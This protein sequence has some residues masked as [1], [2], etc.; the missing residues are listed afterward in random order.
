MKELQENILHANVT[1]FSDWREQ[2]DFDYERVDSEIIDYVNSSLNYDVL[3]KLID[4]NA[5]DEIAW[6]KLFHQFGIPKD[7]DKSRTVRR[8][9]ESYIN[10]QT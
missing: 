8:H 6:D 1:E 9:I 7:S 10:T 5:T 2:Q 4:N 3:D